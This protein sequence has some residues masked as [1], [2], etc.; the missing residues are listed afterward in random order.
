MRD[1]F[2]ALN[3][4][5]SQLISL[6]FATVADNPVT[7]KPN[8]LE[9]IDEDWKTKISDEVFEGLSKELE[10]L[11]EPGEGAQR[12]RFLTNAKGIYYKYREELEGQRDAMFSLEFIFVIFFRNVGLAFQQIHAGNAKRKVAF[13]KN[14]EM[15]DLQRCFEALSLEDPS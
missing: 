12:G 11:G 2:R 4:P 7:K 10:S 5:S 1:T 3:Q 8:V 6:D 9:G 13:P 14:C 15:E